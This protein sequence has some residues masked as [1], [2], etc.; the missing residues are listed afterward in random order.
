MNKKFKIIFSS[1]I[2]FV[3][4][5][6]LIFTALVNRFPGLTLGI[7][8]CEYVVTEN[9][10]GYY[11]IV[12]TK[13]TGNTLYIPANVINISI[14]SYIGDNKLDRIVVDSENKEYYVEDE[15]LIKNDR[16]LLGANGSTFTFNNNVTT[17][18]Q[19]AFAYCDKIENISIP[20]TITTIEDFA[21]ANCQNINTIYIPKDV[22]TIK[23]NVFYECKNL[24][25]YTETPSDNA[26]WNKYWNCGFQVR[27]NIEKIVHVNNFQYTL[28]DERQTATLL[29][30]LGKDEEVVIP[31]VI[32]YNNITYNVTNA[33]SGALSSCKNITKLVLPTLYGEYLGYLFGAKSYEENSKYIPSTLT[34]VEIVNAKEIGKGA[35][36]GCN[37]LASITM[38]FVG[39][40]S[41]KTHFGYIFGADSAND[42]SKYV[43]STLKEV[44]ITRTTSI[45]DYAF[46]NCSSLTNID[47]SETV[48]NIGDYAFAGC[49]SMITI[50]LP[51]SV[52]RIGA[53]AF[54]DCENLRS[55]VLPFI[56]NGTNN[57]TYLGYLF[58]A[59]SANDNS[60]YVP[61][62]LKE[63]I[64]TKATS[65]GDYAF[66]NCSNLTNIEI[67]NTATS[68][69]KNAFSGCS[70]MATINFPNSVTNIGS[71]AFNGCSSL[72]S[73]EIPNSVTSIEKSAFYN[74]E[75][76]R[77]IVLPFIGNGTSSVTYFGYIFGA[78]SVSENLKY[79]PSAL[80]KVKIT[81][82]E[83]ISDYAFSNCSSL[84][85][86]E[87]SNSLTSI[88]DNAFYSC[89]S[90]TSIEI[91]NSLTSIGEFA[92]DNCT[93]LYEVI[94]YSKLDL[95]P[96]SWENGKIASYAL[97]VNNRGTI[98]YRDSNV[99]D[100]TYNYIILSDGFKFLQYGKLYYLLSYSGEEE[101]PVL[102]YKINGKTY[103][104]QYMDNTLSH[105]KLSDEFVEIPYSMFYNC[106]ALES[107][108]ISNNVSCIRSKVFYNCSNLKR[109]EIPEGVT[110]IERSAFE[111]CNSITTMILPFIG[112]GSRNETHLGYIFGA[113]LASDNSK[114]V[115]ST[116]KEV[117]ITK[118]TSIGDSAFSGCSNLTSIEIPDSVTSIGWYAFSG[119]SG[120]TSIKLSNSVTFIDSHVFANCSNLTS[121]EIPDSITSIGNCAFDNCTGLYEVINHS[122]LD[123]IPGS[124]E[125]GKIANYAL[126]VNNRGTIIYKDSNVTDDTYKYIETEAGF[127]F[128][129]CGEKYYLLSYNGKEEVPVL[130]YKINDKTYYC[131][132]MDNT[133]SHIKLSDEFVEIPNK[134]FLNC[135]VLESIVISNNV[136]C[137]RSEAF[138]NCSGLEKVKILEGV[139]SIGDYAFYNCGGLISIELPTSLTSIGDYA[140]YN[141]SGLTSIKL[142]SSLTSIGGY[143]FYNCSSLE[144]V[145]YEG[146]IE[147][148]ISIKF[149]DISNPMV[150]ATHF[151]MLD[152]NNG[153]YEP[154][155]IIVP[156]GINSI[157][158]GQF[159][160]FTSLVN[161]FLPDSVTRIGGSAFGGCTSLTSIEIPDS[162]TRI[163][164]YAFSDCSSLASIIVDK[165]NKVYDSR[166]NCNAI[167]ETATNKLVIGCKNTIIPNSV[168][169]IGVSAFSGCSNLTS[170]EIPNS[171]TSIGDHAFSGCSSLTSI[172]IPNSATIIRWHAFCDCT[173]LTIYCEADSKPSGWDYGWNPS[174]CPVVWG[175]KK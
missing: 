74:C 112:N 24:N 55:M 138:Y 67:S 171:V 46:Y 160:N 140:F 146:T 91:P 61:S 173:N 4:I 166:N 18:G 170:I 143:A 17:I 65:I 89:S 43:P 118:A 120:L 101:V 114:F 167:I 142:S 69:G 84:T 51:N 128:L 111:G 117:I 134:M 2:G 72:T 104:C 132:Y 137:I 86:I 106:C 144:K 157:N 103:Y 97:K 107:I 12:I 119:C 34:H 168:T 26:G 147:N 149:F 136:S 56:G 44:K 36:Y 62:T 39:N 33:L 32:N 100:D 113:G 123:L 172:E 156:D 48:T 21:F 116:L 154:T 155:K 130:P 93:S 52:R 175:Y 159:R 162:V 108:T 3:T 25:I 19:W 169:S 77:S 8:G 50:N 60:K 58:G 53:N 35:F 23:D 161:I 110:N 163:G 152:E 45:G 16:I 133:L 82:I 38:P 54:A 153:W 88:G 81:K 158:D 122:K 87:L 7:E 64:I 135:Y 68:I 1:L 11:S 148:W 10:G 129:Q 165:D 79:I 22:E 40:G 41:D 109:V 115:P 28:C 99:T 29:K 131:Q 92:F 125:N 174:N 145:Y 47:I 124:L 31:D 6:I 151:Y 105:I 126:K 127:K 141:C 66:Y 70:S 85:N 139:T 95:I 121:I 94:N 63:V 49:N 30:Y 59:D 42:N 98:I 14:A 76:L 27:Y 78:N 164:A 102:P 71:F 150:Y 13:L 75:N 57:V 9:N 96:G 73:I 80:K 20:S 5:S 37:N 15:C 83:S 90:L